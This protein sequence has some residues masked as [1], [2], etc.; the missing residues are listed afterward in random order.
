MSRGAYA[1]VDHAYDVVVVGAGFW[2][3]KMVLDVVVE[4]YVHEP[5]NKFLTLVLIKFATIFAAGLAVF[6]LLKIAFGGDAQ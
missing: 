1:V 2:H 4:D 5:G 3:L 6:A